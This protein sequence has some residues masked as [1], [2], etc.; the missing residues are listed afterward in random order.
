VVRSY[1]DRGNCGPGQLFRTLRRH[2]SCVQCWPGWHS[3][4]R[5]FPM[6]VID[7]GV[8]I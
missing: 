7:D 8:V 6:P 3:G 4:Q 5:L 1:P 2:K